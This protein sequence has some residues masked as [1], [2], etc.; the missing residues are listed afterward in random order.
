MGRLVI[1]RPE[2]SNR[3]VSGLKRVHVES[4]AACVFVG[5]SMRLRRLWRRNTAG[6]DRQARDSRASMRLRRLWRRNTPVFRSGDCNSLHAS[7]RAVKQ[8][9]VETVC[10]VLPETTFGSF[11][12]SVFKVRERYPVSGRHT[13]ARNG[14]F[15]QFECAYPVSTPSRCMI[16]SAP[17]AHLRRRRHPREGSDPR[18]DS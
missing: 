8:S 2:D 5:A 7:F 11:Q 17:G 18:S 9:V 16:S 1:L 13:A 6:G 4:D 15:R 12:Y 10:S 14:G 3:T